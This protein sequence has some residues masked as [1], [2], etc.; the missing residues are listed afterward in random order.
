MMDDE[1]RL[2]VCGHNIWHHEDMDGGIHECDSCA[3][4]QFKDASDDAALDE[5]K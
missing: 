4:P 3:C 5:P 2:C 1:N